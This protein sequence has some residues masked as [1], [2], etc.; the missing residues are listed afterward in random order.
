MS[1]GDRYDDLGAVFLCEWVRRSSD[2]PPTDRR[3]IDVAILDMHHDWPNLGHDSIVR[4]VEE[5]A[6]DLRPL[7]EAAGMRIRTLSYDVRRSLMIPQAPGDRHLLYV[8]TGGPGH[9]DPRRN[10]GVSDGTQGIREDASWERPLFRLFDAIQ[11]DQRA[12]LLAVCHTFGVLCRWAGVARPVLRGVDKGGKSSGV[13]ENALTAA[14]V[15]HPWFARLAAQ[16]R[17]GRHVRILDSRLFDLIPESP[18]FPAGVL[19]IGHDVDPRDR[20]EGE[21]VTMLEFARDGEGTLPRV[22]AVNHHPEVRDV[23]RQMHLLNRKLARGEVTREWYDER[24]RALRQ[25]HATAESQAELM[26]TSQYTLLAPLRYHLYRLV[27]CRAAD[28][29][30]STDL[31]EEQVLSR[32]SGTLDREPDLDGP[33]H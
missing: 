2:V 13:R 7:L 25:M 20:S 12:V 21:A 18:H 6:H 27:R 8:G 19:P 9:I 11:S 3:V 17:D 32:P 10:D 14:A 30:C 33:G 29:G 1:S 26:L 28:L 16:L 4:A 5:I 15:D 22:F 23:R 31:S 24:A